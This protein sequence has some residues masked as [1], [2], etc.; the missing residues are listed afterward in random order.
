MEWYK[1][2]FLILLCLLILYRIYVFLK[3][4]IYG[5]EEDVKEYIDK[6][7]DDFSID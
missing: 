3:V 5:S 6:L 4:I 7:D 2:G 1:I